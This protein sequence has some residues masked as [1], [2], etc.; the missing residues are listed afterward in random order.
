MSGTDY[1]RIPNMNTTSSMECNHHKQGVDNQYSFVPQLP[2][3]APRANNGIM[4]PENF[5]VNQR[6]NYPYDYYMMKHYFSQSHGPFG[7]NYFNSFG[8]SHPNANSVD[9]SSHEFLNRGTFNEMPLHTHHTSMMNPSFSS[10]SY[11]SDSIP[12][13]IQKNDVSPNDSSQ[14]SIG[15]TKSCPQ[16]NSVSMSSMPSSTKSNRPLLDLTNQANKSQSTELQDKRQSNERGSILPN[17]DQVLLNKKSTSPTI[18]IEEDTCGSED[19]SSKTVNSTKSIKSFPRVKHVLKRVKTDEL[20]STSTQRAESTNAGDDAGKI[21]FDHISS[22]YPPISENRNKRCSSSISPSSSVSSSP[23]TIPS[24]TEEGAEQENKRIKTSDNSESFLG[25]LDI[26]CQAVTIVA[27]KQDKENKHKHLIAMETLDKSKSCSCPRSRCIKLYCECFQDGRMCSSL[28][29]CKK[30]KNTKEETGPNGLRT[31]AIQN[32]LS[33]NPHAFS[34]DKR[35]TPPPSHD[36]IVCRCVKSR[37]LKLYCDCF[38]SGQ[39]CGQFCMCIGCLNTEEESGETGRRTVAQ[40]SC[41][42]RNPDAFIKKVKVIGA[43]CSCRNS[44]YVIPKY[45]TN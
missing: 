13:T 8:P 43:G 45:N 42:Q 19:L 12:R 28:C 36:G 26:L 25:K 16:S 37:C 27:T 18:K 14:R 1:N 6:F 35:N 4:T 10:S 34:K 38:Q 32:I 9:S 2:H 5:A 30:C 20:N 7:R 31:K 24:I 3:I 39:V 22:Y 29:S 11:F 21:N 33:R 23:L 40:R 17:K 15:Q 41:L 44:R